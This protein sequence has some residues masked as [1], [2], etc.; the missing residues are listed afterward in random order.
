MQWL[1]RAELVA[2]VSN[3]GG[4]GI[5]T[6]HHFASTTELRDEIRKTRSLT[7]K[8][9]AVN[10]NLF[11]AARPVKVDEY[12]DV[13][14]SEGVRF[15]ETSGR[16]PEP[17]MKQLKDGGVTVMHKVT[18]VR[19]AQSAERLGVDAIC[20]VGT[21]C[22]GH[23]GEEDVTSL[24]LVPRVVDSVKVPVVAAGGFADARG[25]LAALALGAE[26]I[27]MGTRFMATI[28]CLAHPQIKDWLISARETDTL[29]INRGIRNTMRAM[30]T[31][32]SLK[33]LELDRKGAALEELMPIIAGPNA[34]RALTTGE[35]NAGVISCGQVVGLVH[36]VKSAKQVIDEIIDGAE[37]IRKRL[38][39]T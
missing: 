8:P 11:P 17:H 26:G 5:L 36:E 32:T 7:G 21:E 18:G 28:E 34:C 37:A 27:L 16:S 33:A 30:K 24:V 23:P 19:F 14:I 12:I 3:A 15:V 13:A 25:L 1:A 29:M 31:E 10:I 38:C 20:I 22:G 4:L 6:S 9:F 35:V 39:F 2:A